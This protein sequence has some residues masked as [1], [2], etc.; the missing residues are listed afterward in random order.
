VSHRTLTTRFIP[1][2]GIVGLVLI[3]TTIG[4]QILREQRLRLP[5]DDRFT[6]QVELSSGQALTPGQ[7]QSVTVAGV[8]VGEIARVRLRDGRARVTLSIERAK[9]PAVHRDATL[10][11]RPRTPLQDMTVDIDP[12]SAGAPELGEDDVLPAAQTTPQ[13]NLD[14]ILGALDVDTRAWAIS[15]VGGFAQ[16]IRGQGD[17]LRAALKASRPT[18]TLTRRVAAATAD[19]RRQLARA[20]HSLRTLTAAVAD[21]EQSLGTLVTAGDATFSTLAGE[22]DAL[23]AGLQR[24]P[25]TLRS[26]RTALAAAQPFADVAAPAFTR[27]VP[28]ARA[29][30]ATLR[31][32]DPLQRDALPALRELTAIAPGT[33]RVARELRPAV[34]D[35]AAA[36]P[37]AEKAFTTLEHLGDLFAYNPP[38][39]EEGYLFWMAWFLHNGHQF[40]SGQDAN[41]P[42]WRG[43]VQFSC[44]TAFSEPLTGAILKPVLDIAK[45]C[46]T[47][48]PVTRAKRRAAR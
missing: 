20:I 27:L 12:G 48:P 23:R 39:K 41:G 6:V 43:I 16:G 33:R 13:V 40:I 22:D 1:A 10:F 21:E 31:A 26:A 19:R 9:L 30:P 18:L 32:L 17:A 15:L 14:E 35:L 45:P 25:G 34:S 38:G 8:E 24:L 29:L 4:F 42:F 47:P 11:V 46:P 5:W 36:N 28:V 44:S 3:A 2:V 37:D 7:G